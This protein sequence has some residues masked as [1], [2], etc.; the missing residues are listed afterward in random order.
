MS[1]K[2]I[3][4][5]VDDIK[6][7]LSKPQDYEF[8]S[9]VDLMCANIYT[10]I[11][12]KLAKRESQ[13]NGN[14]L[15]MSAIGTPDRKMWYQDRHAEEAEEMPPEAYLK[16]LYGDLIEELILML[17]KVAGHEVKGQQKTLEIDGVMG[18]QDCEIDGEL[19][20]VKSAS[21]FAFNKFNNNKLRED[22][23]FHYLDQLNVYREANPDVRKDRAHFL[24]ID[25]QLGKICLDTYEAN[26][27]D[28]AKEIT[29]KK[30]ML[31]SDTVPPKCYMPVPDGKSG[32]MKLDT[33]CS[34]CSF[35]KKCWPTMR[36]FLYSSGPRF[37]TE[38]K[39]VPDVPEV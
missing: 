30:A 33:A 12:E 37:L 10:L 20:D 38:V 18:H 5:L 24:A 34:Y 31:E 27:K 7:V 19:V 3:D 16:F 17:A 15:R 1:K 6:D 11:I 26:D 32:N 13:K 39:R 8:G 35:K 21:S 22:D 28:Y 23:S 25:K 4:S 29:R 2:T 36:T 14:A 9:E